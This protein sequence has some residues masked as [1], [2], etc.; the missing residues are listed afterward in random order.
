MVKEPKSIK[1]E[2]QRIIKD[3]DDISYENIEPEKQFKVK[4]SSN[5]NYKVFSSSSLPFIDDNE[6]LKNDCDEYL[7]E[8]ESMSNTIIIDCNNNNF[9]LPRDANNESK[10]HSKVNTSATHSQICSFND[11]SFEFIDIDDL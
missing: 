9:E 7:I 5:I 2:N 3:E 10:H 6:N 11:E 4:S 1:T 8:K